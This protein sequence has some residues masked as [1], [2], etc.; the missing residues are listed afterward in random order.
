MTNDTPR[1]I[2][3]H[4]P[5]PR[6][7]RGF[8][9]T[10]QGGVS[11]GRYASLNLG[12]HVGDEPGSVA[13]NRSRL[14]A[15]LLLPAEPVWMKQVHGTDVADVGNATGDVEADAAYT[16][17]KGVVCAVLTADCLPLL[18]CDRGGTEVAVVHV[19]WRGLTAGVIE[20]GLHAF[21]SAPEELSVWLGPAIGARAYEVGDDVRDAAIGADAQAVIAFTAGARGK[22]YMDIYR[23]AQL[24]LAARGVGS[25]HGGDYCTASQPDLFFS[26]RR[27]RV[28][29]RMASLIWLE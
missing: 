17:R 26:Y 6:N 18:I 13:E 25:V 1:L 19:G 20:A 12:G 16:N 5:A 8:S 7:V 21:R 27:D 2:R 28:T 14:R 24:R 22:W 11:G 15:A 10:R 3:P 4:W 9:T 29:G 23:A